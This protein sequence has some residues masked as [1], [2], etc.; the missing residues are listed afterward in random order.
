MKINVYTDGG[1]RGNPGISGYGLVV[2]NVQGQTI[3]QESKFLGIKTNNEAEYLSFIAALTWVK[4]HCDDLGIDSID[5]YSDSQLI[6]RQIKGQY[7]V[8]AKNLLPLFNSVK[9]LIVQIN[10]PFHFQERNNHFDLT[11]ITIPPMHS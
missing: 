3:Y 10:L 1:S 7:K 4:N 11:Y 5:F 6:I 8:K 9:S 2:T